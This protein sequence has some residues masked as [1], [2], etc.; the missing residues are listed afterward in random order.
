MESHRG[1][2]WA[3]CCSINSLDVGVDN[4]LSKFADDVKL[5]RTANVLEDGSA[6]QKDLDR[7]K[8]CTP[9]EVQWQNHSSL[10]AKI[11]NTNTKKMILGCSVQKD[12][13]VSVGHR[14]NPKGSCTKGECRFK[15]HR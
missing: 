13:G 15:S 12:L 14:L 3:R 2:S 7:L 9:V 8:S 5:G 6:I 10:R 11:K 4:F 1:L